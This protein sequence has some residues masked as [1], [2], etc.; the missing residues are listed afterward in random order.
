VRLTIYRKMVIG[1]G[2]IILVM[3]AVTGYLLSEL[4]TFSTTVREILFFDVRSLD[5]ARQ[6]RATL[7]DEE[8]HARKYLLSADTTYLELFRETADHL[9]GQLDSLP[10][11]LSGTSDRSIL[12]RIATTQAKLAGMITAVDGRDETAL[13]SID[14]AVSDSMESMNA[15][16]DLLITG[17]RNSM[18]RSMV[19]LEE[20]TDRSLQIALLITLCAIGGTI[21]VAFLIT[22]TITRP[23]DELRRGTREVAR[24]VFT[25]IAIRSHDETA[26]LAK[27]FNDMSAKLRRSNDQRAEMMQHISHEIRLPLQTMHS[28][29]YLLT[30]ER[31]GPLTEG[32]RKLLA[33]IRSNIDRIADFSDQFLDLAK[34]EADMMEFAFEDVDLATLI[35]PLLEAAQVT[36][37]EKELSVHL[38]AEAVQPVR[39]DAAKLSQVIS[40]LLS[41]AIKYTPRGGTITVQLGQGTHGV[42]IDVRDTGIGIHPDDLPHVFTR[43]YR[44]RNSAV[45]GTKGTGLGLALVKAIVEKHHGRVSVRSTLGEGT[46]MTVELPAAH[47]G[48]S[49]SQEV[50]HETT[51]VVQ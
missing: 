27:A 49:S 30:Q 19:R 8:R 31:T 13:S 2:I 16:L 21:I 23:L 40:N 10:P 28:A 24:G 46:T 51:R 4:H 6:L 48:G 36:A 42:T 1:F 9:R 15:S 50:S 43:F 47:P 3:I 5:A 44:A 25:P 37:A 11:F 7:D 29:Y 20:A 41:N 35:A 22:R 32:Q 38:I 45:S 33:T 14:A 17:V 18:G 26:I 34:I 12:T 39:A